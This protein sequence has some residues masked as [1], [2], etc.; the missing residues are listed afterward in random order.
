MATL[1]P[2]LATV[3]LG[4]LD[5]KSPLRLLRG[6][7]LVL[8]ALFVKVCEEYWAATVEEVVCGYGV[9]HPRTWT[10]ELQRSWACFMSQQDDRY[11]PSSESYGEPSKLGRG[12][13]PDAIWPAWLSYSVFGRERL[14]GAFK[15]EKADLVTFP[16]NKGRYCNMLPFVFADPAS[17]PK[18]F[19]DY[20]PLIMRCMEH[21]HGSEIAED[22]R[23]ENDETIN[24]MDLDRVVY[25]TVDE[26][27]PTPGAS[28]R[29]PGL[30]IESGGLTS[31]VMF[32]D[33]TTFWLGW[34]HGSLTKMG[35]P[36][37]GI[38]MASTVAGSTRLY[39]CRIS[40]SV[41]DVV[42][43]GGDVERMRPLLEEHVDSHTL[44]AGELAWMTDRTPHESLPVASG[45]RQY[46]RLVVGDIGGWFEGH[47]TANPLVA[48]NAPIIQ[49]DKFEAAPP[50]KWAQGD[51]RATEA[52]SLFRD[53]LEGYG[54]GHIY[55]H[56]TGRGLRTLEDLEDLEEDD[57]PRLL[58][59]AFMF[60]KPEEKAL[61]EICKNLKTD[62]KPAFH[63]R[64]RGGIWPGSM[65]RES[66]DD[67]EDSD[68]EAGEASVA[69]DP[70]AALDPE[71]IA[72]LEAKLKALAADDPSEDEAEVQQKAL[73]KLAEAKA[74]LAEAG[75]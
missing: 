65:C 33:M 40:D 66:D 3:L 26:R 6:N 59:G 53:V 1:D 22:Q 14:S 64:C 54:V 36:R 31:G 42:G 15:R 60:C 48:P 63:W 49:G 70:P 55:H 20:V 19:H 27:T 47:S 73:L 12:D 44:E 52:H 38:F 8:R 11:N 75:L 32:D 45:E 4:T 39:N 51:V 18:E 30:H 25:L 56:L 7:E 57:V 16:P 69:E 37:G 58:E 5:S 23:F 28:Q 10:R 21:C 35:Q 62:E 13:T 2:A 72:R 43:P 41:G 68:E 24:P 71:K 34:G 9:T 29:R 17:L 46:F 74:A 50:R 67:L 61:A